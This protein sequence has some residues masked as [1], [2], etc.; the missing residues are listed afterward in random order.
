[1]RDVYIITQNALAD[2]TY[3]DYIRAQYNRSTQIDPPFFQELLRSDKERRDNYS[4]NVLAR[5]V[6]PLD[7]LFEG[8]GARIEKRRRTF[9]SWFAAGDFKDLPRFSA[10]L[11][12]GPQQDAVSRFLYDNLAPE[13]QK[14]LSGNTTDDRSLRSSLARDLN[15]LIDRELQIKKSIAKKKTH[16]SALELDLAEGSGSE[17]KRQ[18]VQALEKEITELFKIPPL[19]EPER[20]KSVAISQYLRDFINQNPQG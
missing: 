4:T 16:K 14:L 15:I 10:H 1:R 17:S 8:L 3:L 6:Q 2:G 9:T 20:F 19:Y 13:T 12:P 18:R 5:S 7:R 11:R